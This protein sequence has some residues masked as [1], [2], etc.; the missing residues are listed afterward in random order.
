MVLADD[1]PEYRSWLRSLVESSPEFQ[2]IGEAN[3]GWEAVKLV[4]MLSPDLLICDVEMPELDGLDVARQVRD[5]CPEVRVILISSH[6]ER[7]HVR[8]ANAEGALGFISKND[9][10]LE[11]LTRALREVAPP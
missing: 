9:L 11:S 6:R 4:Q 2:V 10:S 8:L 1:L 5:N 7:V 3:N